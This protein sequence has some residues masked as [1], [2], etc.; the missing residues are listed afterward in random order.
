M[1]LACDGVFDVMSNQDVANFIHN[2]LRQSQDPT[3]I[4]STQ[5]LAEICDLLLQEVL[6][7]GSTDNLSVIVILLGAPPVVIRKEVV[8]GLE[9]IHRPNS[10][11]FNGAISSPLN[12]KSGSSRFKKQLQF[13]DE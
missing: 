10:D 13:Q 1:V 4:P 6:R 2:S 9:A 12:I 3:S 7:R 5:R 8:A 11:T